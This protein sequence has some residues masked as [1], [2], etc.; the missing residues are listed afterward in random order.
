MA[1][2]SAYGASVFHG[3][4]TI[5]NYK[6]RAATYQAIQRFTIAVA[7]L[8]ILVNLTALAFRLFRSFR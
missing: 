7:A 1:R 5:I 2:R 4:H 8:T 3:E 6:N